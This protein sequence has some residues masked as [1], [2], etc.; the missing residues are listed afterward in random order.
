MSYITFRLDSIA[1]ENAASPPDLGSNLD[2]ILGPN[3][4]DFKDIEDPP[5]LPLDVRIDL[6]HQAWKEAK[7]KLPIREAARIFGVEYSTIR[8]RT[9]GAVPKAIASQAMQR[10]T[11]SEEEAL[12]DWILEL[13]SWNW[14]VRVK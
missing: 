11:V 12:Q 5:E 7:G 14:P 8:D 10:L 9:K 4:D 2:P 3:D 6:A 1:V 13:A